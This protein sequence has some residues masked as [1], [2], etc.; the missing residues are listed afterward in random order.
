MEL[1]GRVVPDPIMHTAHTIGD[2]SRYFHKR[3]T[4]PERLFEAL[5]GK[6]AADLV[7]EDL[8]LTHGNASRNLGGVPKLEPN[9]LTSLPNV[10]ISQRRVTAIDKERSLG[11]WKVIEH[12]LRERGLPI[13]GDYERRKSLLPQ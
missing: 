6:D 12:E 2:L 5:A 7:D 8:A 4:K 1:S 11:R 3:L 9:A 10:V 13:T